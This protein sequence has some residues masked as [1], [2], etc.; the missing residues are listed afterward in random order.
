MSSSSEEEFDTT[1]LVSA[2]GISRK[3]GPKKIDFGIGS[4][5][6]SA[7]KSRVAAS[8]SAVASEKNLD[9]NVN[10]VESSDYQLT[11]LTSVIP[12]DAAAGPSGISGDADRPRPTVCHVGEAVLCA[13][14]G[15]VFGEEE[16]DVV[17][18][19]VGEGEEVTSGTEQRDVGLASSGSDDIVISEEDVEE[20]VKGRKRHRQPDRWK[21]VI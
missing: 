4:F 19:S 15:V 2:L 7:P 9:E 17:S 6:S 11:E 21:R 13:G 14:G 3:K 16:I 10:V 8:V 12:D 5:Y 1:R 20:S 18:L